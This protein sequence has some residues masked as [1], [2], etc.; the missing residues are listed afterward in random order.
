[1]YEWFKQNCADKSEYLRKGTM[2]DDEYNFIHAVFDALNYKQYR[3]MMIQQRRDLVMCSLRRW[4]KM[5]SFGLF[6]TLHDGTLGKH[7]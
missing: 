4:S 1:M 5:C 3:S 7:I 6:R 2:H